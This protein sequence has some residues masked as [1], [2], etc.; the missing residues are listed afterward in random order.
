MRTA[1][2][3]LRLDALGALLTATLTAFAAWR[4]ELFGLPAYHLTVLSLLALGIAAYGSY[5]VLQRAADHAFH[6]LRVAKA[7][8]L[9]LGL[10]AALLLG[11]YA[12]L[13][14]LAWAYFILEGIVVVL[15]VR[16]E[17]RV[18][19]RTLDGDAEQA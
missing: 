18:V 4:N 3:V 11:F 17:Y 10:T 12:Q 9:Y 16:H 7:N 8:L 1:R 2:Q 14:P 6:L 19:R 13:T 15:L 5:F